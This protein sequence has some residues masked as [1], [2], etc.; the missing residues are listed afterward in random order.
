MGR[1]VLEV[2]FLTGAGRAPQAPR[3][4]RPADR[5][6]DNDLLDLKVR[7]LFF[8]DGRR[9]PL[10]GQG[11]ELGTGPKGTLTA[12]RSSS[13]E[14][15]PTP[16]FM[17]PLARLG[18]AGLG[19]GA[20]RGAAQSAGRQQV[21]A[22]RTEL[23][24]PLRT[25]SPRRLAEAPAAAKTPRAV[26]RVKNGAA[27]LAKPPAAAAGEAPG[28]APG[29]G[30]F[31]ERSQ[32]RLSLSASFEALAIYF[33][34]MNSFDEEDAGTGGAAGR[35]ETGVG[36]RGR[37]QRPAGGLCGAGAARV[38]RGRGGARRVG[39][40]TRRPWW[41]VG[42]QQG[43]PGPGPTEQRPPCALGCVLQVCLCENKGFFHALALLRP[44]S[45]YVQ[46]SSWRFRPF[47]ALS[48]LLCEA[49]REEVVLLLDVASSRP[50]IYVQSALGMIVL[51][52][53]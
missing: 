34:C 43:P 4:P 46:M 21:A 15:R 5:P 19:G 18:W 25:A 45:R 52:C 37:G 1:N 47:L 44:K 53:H 12:E 32:S 27:K 2:L 35:G 36:R 49:L 48:S 30:L 16:P 41:S 26:L 3:S 23:R 13:G 29:S 51:G 17:P 22:L 24:A 14:S 9:S 33:P 42:C 7:F 39:Q 28:G 38:P 10:A 50:L 8:P 6:C 20:G 40:Q 11:L 31:M